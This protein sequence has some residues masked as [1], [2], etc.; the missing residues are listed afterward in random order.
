MLAVVVSN[1]GNIDAGGATLVNTFAAQAFTTDASPYN[2]NSVTVSVDTLGTEVVVKIFDDNAGDPGNV[3]ATLTGDATPA[4]GGNDEVYTDTAG[5][6]LNAST[7]YWVVLSGTTG[8]IDFTSDDSQVGN[9]TIGN[10]GR[11]STTIGPVVW[12]GTTNMLQIAIDATPPDIILSESASS[13]NVTEGGVTDSY[14]LA[15]DTMPAG[16]VTIT[17]TADAE[18]E[19]SLNG[20]V[21]TGSVAPVFTDLT[22]Q[23]IH[24]RAT[25]DTVVEGAESSTIGH[26]VTS[27]TSTSYPTSTFANITANVTDNDTAVLTVAS[28]SS[29]PSEAVGSQNVGVTLT[30]T[31]NGV[32]GTGTLASAVTV[33]L[34]ALGSS[35]ATG[36]DF[37]LPS[38]PMVTFVSGSVSATVNA[39]VAINN[40]TLVESDETIDLELTGLVGIGTQVTIDTGNDNHTITIDDNDTA[41]VEF[42]MATS[43]PGED[44]GAHVVMVRLSIPGGGVLQDAATFSVSA[45]DVDTMASD[46]TLNTAIVTFAMGSG[47]GDL[48]SVT[49]TPLADA[50]IEGD[51]DV[52]LNVAVTGGAATLGA[53][54]SHTVTI[55]D[56]DSASLAIVATKSV[57]EAGAGQTIEVTLTTS[58]ATLAPGISL[59]ANVVDAG[60]GQGIAPHFG[61]GGRPGRPGRSGRVGRNVSGRAPAARRPRASH[62]PAVHRPRAGRTQRCFSQGSM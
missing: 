57:T 55:Q 61:G 59:M 62:S 12:T 51:E 52:T 54:S 30:I 40:D 44:A 18:T 6:V 34:Q 60:G 11:T 38:S 7:Q 29:N 33:N 39:A 17:V 3:V 19:V 41:T 21:Y 20:V 8:A 25:N 15:L 42:V 14:T 58:G 5:T 36:S 43:N 56:A 1:L 26:Q 48:K 47:N 22:A 27:S 32:S 49:I 37:S 53:Q 24:V 23:T 50:L 10:D 9:W 28:T 46:Y 16:N 4:G 13:T 45:V 31:G 35:T 2:L